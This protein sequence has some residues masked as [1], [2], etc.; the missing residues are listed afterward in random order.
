M[1]LEQ[2]RANAERVLSADRDERVEALRT[3]VLER[4]LDPAV[5]LV[6]VRPRR[7]EDRPA[8]RE[9]PRDLARAERLEHAIDEPAPSGADPDDVVPANL[10]APRDSPDDRVQPR[11]IASAGEDPYSHAVCAEG[12]SRTHT[13]LAPHRILS[14][15]RLP[16]PPLRP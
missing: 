9:Q 16:V 10:R 15:A 14:P 1:L 6:R 8:A 2:P 7:A 4:A 12:G 11:A 5:D 3:E 13:E